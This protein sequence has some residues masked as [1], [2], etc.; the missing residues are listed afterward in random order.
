MAKILRNREPADVKRH[1][2]RRAVA[3]AE[4]AYTARCREAEQHLEAAERAQAKRVRD[5]QKALER[6]E[7]AYDARRLNAERAVHNAR[8]GEV[9]A[10]IAKVRLYPDRLEA[11]DG[12][13]KL[14]SAVRATV[15]ATG[16]KTEKA[17][18][19]ETLLLLDTP[20]YDAVIQIA[21]DS[22]T[23]A[24]AFAAKV[25]TAGKN[26]D[27]RHKAHAAAIEAAEAAL[28]RARSDQTAIEEARAALATAEA[29]TESIA[30]AAEAADIAKA[31]TSDLDAARSQLHELDPDASVRTTEDLQRKSRGMAIGRFWRRRSIWAKIAIVI[32]LVLIALTAL[33]A[34]LGDPEDGNVAASQAAADQPD[35]RV[36]LTVDAPSSPTVTVR[37][38]EQEVA[39]RVTEG[40]AVEINGEDV[41][42]VNGAY[43]TV[44]PLEAGQNV[45]TLRAT[46][47]GSLQRD[48][49]L[50][51]TRELPTLTLRIDSPSSS[52]TDVRVP[53]Y[54]IKG[55]AT[56]GSIVRLNGQRLKLRGIQF[57]ATVGLSQGRNEF[58]IE[59][60]KKGHET[61]QAN[62]DIVRRLSAAEVA[63]KQA[64]ARQQFI[65]QSRTIPYNQ[66]IKNPDAYVG[67]KVKYYGEILQ[68]QES[69]GG[70]FM[71][72]Y[73]TNLGY[74][75]WSE[76]IW[77]NYRG[78]VRGAQG[79][80]LTVYGIVTGSQSY[81]TQ[82]GGETFVP[83]VEARYIV[84]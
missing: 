5:A 70:G 32:A 20:S 43:R 71:L 36:E 28:E 72:L 25:N 11:P 48:M 16:A 18:S 45:L 69:G 52:L 83:E 50:T 1:Q 58:Q 2:T 40:S 9:E 79:D 46:K 57:R 34:V 15:E 59:A 38:D 61:N 47:P 6:A 33:G 21:P 3:D 78:H 51:I 19:R 82:I 17:D 64:N 62:F 13:V 53:R 24:R 42:V 60:V 67:T 81:E 14:S 54:D 39:G 68:I 77:V 8:A 66:L 49:T 75:I 76:Q 26:A 29:D 10:A 80:Q 74:D 55:V 30:R 35:Q 7:Q 65:N 84:E 22:T 44:V 41:P 31:D 12:T 73:V 4:K 23:M 63:A 37:A 56:R 27:A